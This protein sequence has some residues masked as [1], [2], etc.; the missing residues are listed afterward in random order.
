MDM[1]TNLMEQRWLQIF[2]MPISGVPNRMPTINGMP[3]GRR[4]RIPEAVQAS[5]SKW[6]SYDSNRQDF[7]G[8]GQLF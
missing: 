7:R 1:G 5:V 8:H 3:S 2:V 4:R 6:A